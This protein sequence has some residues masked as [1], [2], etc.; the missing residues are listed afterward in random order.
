M[1]KRINNLVGSLDRIKMGDERD[2]NMKAEELNKKILYLLSQENRYLTATELAEQLKVSTKTIYRHI[3]KIN[4]SQNQPIF[5]SKGK[6]FKL[7][8]QTTCPQTLSSEVPFS[9]L[10]KM[11]LRLLFYSPDSLSLFDLAE[12]YFVSVPTVEKDFMTLKETYT[13]KN[14]QFKRQNFQ[15]KVIGEEAIIRQLIN[16]ILQEQIENLNQARVF[17]EGKTSFI[18]AQIT[19]MERVL[20]QSIPYPYNVNIFSHLLILIRRA[21]RGKETLDLIYDQQEMKEQI[22]LYPHLYRLAE[23]IIKNIDHHFKLNISETEVLYLFQYLMASG[24][25]K[26]RENLSIRYSKRT[27]EICSIIIERMSQIGHYHF[28]KSLLKKDLIPHISSLLHRLDNKISVGNAILNQIK[29]EYHQLYEDVKKVM[30][31]VCQT[32]HLSGLS[33]NEIGFIVIYFAK[34]IE[35]RNSLRVLVICTSGIGTAQL[36]STKLSRYFPDLEIVDT[37]SNLDQNLELKVKGKVDFIIS[38]VPLKKDFG[39]PNVVISALLNDY[40]KERIQH[41]KEQLSNF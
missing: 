34:N 11:L 19:M 26:S 5:I 18:K 40:D 37:A 32:Y 9:R 36:I 15:I 30:D 41:V 7:N 8:S 25:G 20:G 17:G 4:D 23:A 24:L 29:L 2:E 22:K 28:N 14:L 1:D 39:L 21:T 27:E 13:Q 6:G 12:K 16:E 3:N 38:T 35:F 33:E 10:D 31:E